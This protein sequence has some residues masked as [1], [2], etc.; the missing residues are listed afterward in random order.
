MNKPGRRLMVVLVIISIILAGT[1]LPVSAAEWR[2]KVDPWVMQTASQGETE[3]L[4]YFNRP[5]RSQCCQRTS[6]QT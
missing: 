5:G 1:A 3:F 2:A 4:V 6:H